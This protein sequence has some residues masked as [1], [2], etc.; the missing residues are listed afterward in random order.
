MS[1]QPLDALKSFK[2]LKKFAVV[3][4]FL[5]LLT[6]TLYSPDTPILSCSEKLVALMKKNDHKA[7]EIYIE[8]KY[9]PALDNSTK[10]D[11]LT[12]VH[13][14]QDSK[15][16]SYKIKVLSLTDAIIRLEDSSATLKVIFIRVEDTSPYMIR[17]FKEI[18]C[19][20][21]EANI[22]R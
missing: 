6:P 21:T 8:N 4:L 5:I 10:R 16:K 17:E 18:P 9:N 20:S 3:F 19:D 22:A 11:L 1:D 13:Q 7:A 2:I 14:M 12:F 15:I